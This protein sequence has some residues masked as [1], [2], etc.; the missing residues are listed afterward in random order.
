MK[1][2]GIIAYPIT[3]FH[4]DTQAVDVDALTITL[5]AL[6][7]QQ[8][9]A[10]VP[11]GSAG[12][13][14]YLS[15]QEWQQVAQKSIE[16]VNQ[17]VPVMLGISELTTAMA[18]QKAQKAEELGADLIMVIPVSYWKLNDQEIYDYYQQIAASTKLPIMVYNNPATSGVD[19]SPELIV[20]MFQK[21]ENICMVKDSTGDIQRMHK[22][23]ELSQGQLPFYNGCN[24]LALEAFCAG[25]S[26]W[27]T[28]A[29]NLLGQLPSQL[30]QAVKDG[31]L[32][33]AKAL[34]YRQLP[35]LR[36]IVQGG[37]PKTVKAGL[38]ELGFSV[39]E[40]RKPLQHATPLEVQQLKSLMALAKQA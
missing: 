34:F 22:F 2:E 36:F 13:S 35:L 12:E 16:V 10:I 38:N 29:P 1:L 18:I 32:E 37:L 5:N 31:D 11:L 26:G 7:E 28:V 33:H 24:P 40:P 27:C 39:G 23:H 21:I 15:W 14:A 8:C 20:K 9:N 4:P 19:M 30:Y 25:A 6:L 3:P 17:R